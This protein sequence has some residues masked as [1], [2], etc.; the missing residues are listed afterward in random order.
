M[1]RRLRRRTGARPGSRKSHP[2]RTTTGPLVRWSRT[3]TTGHWAYIATLVLTDPSRA[4]AK[5]PRPRDPTTR[6]CAF[7]A[8]RRSSA[9]ACPCASSSVTA[10]RGCS[11]PH[12]PATSRR[13]A[14]SS[15]SSFGP[16]LTATKRSCRAPRNSASRPAHDA[17]S[18]DCSE[19]STPTTTVSDGMTPRS[20]RCGS[21]GRARVG[22]AIVAPR[23]RDDLRSRSSERPS[24][25]TR[26]GRECAWDRPWRSGWFRRG[27]GAWCG[28]RIRR[29][30]AVASCRA[31]CGWWRSGRRL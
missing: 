15:S 1:L 10:T 31:R 2:D 27:R 3:T 23:M 22:G 29:P 13:A 5:P 24:A 20:L 30:Q 8:L 9:A 17:A 19:P 28:G 25:G 16:S 21:T 7:A 12:S 14:R 11:W 4:E 26:A 18:R 6:T